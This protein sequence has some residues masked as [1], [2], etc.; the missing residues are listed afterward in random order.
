MKEVILNC[1]SGHGEMKIKRKLNHIKFRGVDISY[2]V[3]CYVCPTCALEAGT[4]KQTGET[5]KAIAD[6]YRKK[7][8]LLTSEELVEYRKKHKLTQEDLANRMN[9]GVASIKRWE[10]AIIQSKSMNKMLRFTLSGGISGDPCTGNRPFSIPRIKIVMNQLELELK[11]KVLKKGDKMLF[12]SKYAW[13]IDMVAFRETGQSMTGA[14]YAAL[15]Y[16]PQLN[17]YKELVNEIIGAE[18]AEAEQ[19]TDEEGRIIRKIALRF[20]R[21]QQVYDAAH[22]ELIWQEKT[23]GAMIPYTDAS[24]LMEI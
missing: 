11:R 17:N 24:R 4:L 21:N 20:P 9:V 19:L 12:A 10:G 7:V 14:T 2:P 13:Y 16:G 3:D 23:T 1:P 22:R 15:P 6:A 18:E 8:G 5:Q